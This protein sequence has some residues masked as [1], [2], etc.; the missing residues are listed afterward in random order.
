MSSMLLLRKAAPD[1]HNDVF[2]AATRL[3]FGRIRRQRL[4]SA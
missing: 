3:I 4:K 2:V 1:R